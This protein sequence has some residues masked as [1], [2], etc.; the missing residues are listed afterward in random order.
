MVDARGLANCVVVVLVLTRTTRIAIKVLVPNDFPVVCEKHAVSG[1]QKL[2]Q[3]PPSL[4]PFT[5]RKRA[6]IPRK[7]VFKVHVALRT[8]LVPP[9]HGIDRFCELRAAALVDAAGV[10][11]SVA[12]VSL[13][14]DTAEGY[15]FLISGTVLD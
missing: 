7:L 5:R 6:R 14:G 15:D 9:M 4:E 8:L 12:E 10:H 11:P 13:S 1:S 2:L 3:R